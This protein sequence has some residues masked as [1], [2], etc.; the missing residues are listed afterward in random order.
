MDMDASFY[1]DVETF[2]RTLGYPYIACDVFTKPDNPDSPI[3]HQKIGFS[4]CGNEQHPDDPQ[5][6]TRH[7]CKAL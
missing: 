3:F 1:A 4:A 6:E 2:A 5:I 7:Y